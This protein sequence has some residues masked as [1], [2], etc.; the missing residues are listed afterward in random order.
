MALGDFSPSNMAK[1]VLSLDDVMSDSRVQQRHKLMPPLG[2][3]E[4][5]K[6]IE[7]ANWNAV[8]PKDRYCEEFDVV[9]L[10]ES[11]NE[12]TVLTNQTTLHRPPCDIEGEELQSAKKS[13]RLGKVSKFTVKI[14]DEDCGNIFDYESK[15]QLALLQAQKKVLSG[16][17][18]ALPGYISAYAGANRL[19]SSPWTGQDW[20]IGEADGTKTE[21]QQAD[22]TLDKAAYY[23]QLMYQI[24]RLQNPAI[25]DSTLFN[26]SA[27]MATIQ[28]NANAADTGMLNAW[29]YFADRYKNDIENMFAGGYPNS[30]FV[31]DQGNLA[32][33]FVSY[34]PALGQN[35]EVVADKYI[36]SIPA[37]GITLG[38]QPIMIDVTYTKEESQIGS[39]GRCEIVHNFDL[40]LKFDLW[41][42]PKYQSDN[43]T[44]IIELTKGAT[45]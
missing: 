38:G 30:A 19:N 28:A 5:V 21:I 8:R 27:F 31:I 22:L 39:T 45:V 35:N 15:V 12:A 37:A 3:I 10:E 17:A 7:T 33:P 11:D 1:L 43:V 13:Y 26:F 16:V 40:E 44:G 34:F 24:N 42:A 14:K 9:W 32:L 18:K 25:I 6:Q 29:R 20:N 4:M 23:L 2:I 41:Q 36:Y